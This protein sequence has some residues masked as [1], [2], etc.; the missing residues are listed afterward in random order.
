MDDKA[1]VVSGRLPPHL[2]VIATVL[3]Y[4]LDSMNLSNVIYWLTGL[5]VLMY[6]I[7]TLGMRLEMVRQNELAIQPLVIAV[8]GGPD[9]T[10]QLILRNIGRGTAL[11]IRVDDVTLTDVAGDNVPFMMKVQTMDYLEPQTERAPIT[12]LVSASSAMPGA[13]FDAVPSL[14][15]H[16]AVDSCRLTI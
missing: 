16:T 14:D 3:V 1:M 5:I 6:T 8:I 10:R 7:E 15:P 4:Y 11:S 12:E 9:E 2:Y 13:Y